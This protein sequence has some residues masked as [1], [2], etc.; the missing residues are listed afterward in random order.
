M[1][2]IRHRIHELI[3]LAASVA[4]I[5][6]DRNT[7][8]LVLGLAALL[9]FQFLFQNRITGL[10]IGGSLMIGAVWLLIAAVS[11][12]SEMPSPGNRAMERL[13][14]GVLIFLVS[15]TLSVQMLSKYM[16]HPAD[17]QAD[18]DDDFQPRS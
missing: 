4:Y 1:F 14:G 5:L 3:L 16:H 13:A 10:T 8:F 2:R 6:I 9:A 17:T 7:H 18:Q 12:F 15:S 11:E